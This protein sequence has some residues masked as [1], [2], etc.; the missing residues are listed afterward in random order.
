MLEVLDSGH[1]YRNPDPDL[2]SIHAWHATLSSLGGARWVCS[3]D[4]GSAILALD[5]GSWCSSSDDDGRTWSEPVPIAGA[6]T[7]AHPGPH[8]L[9][10]TRLPSGGFVAAGV[11]WHRDGRYARG[12][13]PETSGWAPTD[14]VL[15]RSADGRAWGPLEVVSPPV[16]GPFEVCHRIVTLGDDHWIW[17]LSRWWDWDGDAG[18]DGLRTLWLE[19]RDQGATWAASVVTFDEAAEG[20]AHWEQSVVPLPDGRVVTVAWELEPE[21]STTRPLPWAVV[22]RSEVTTRGTT[23]LLAQTTKIVSLGDDRLLAAYR[24]D[25][26]PGL[27]GTVAR[28]D[29]DGW[30]TLGTAPLW[31]GAMSGMP[32][33]ASVGAELASL[34]FGSP[35]PVLAADGT[36]LVAFWCR[37]ACVHGIRWLRIRVADSHATWAAET[38]RDV[39]RPGPSG[40]PGGHQHGPPVSPGA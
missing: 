8:S 23:G 16:E 27:W 3:F 11:R 22:E 30:H 10:V 19:S 25:D 31:Q 4:L 36:V 21:T 38:G 34:A 33:T 32:G 7:R 39:S 1:I 28:L 20:L 40:T 24:R 5:Y 13:N 9:R 37:E 2:R 6:G 29:G 12:L 26:V 35:S 15:T 18:P 17:P 14:L